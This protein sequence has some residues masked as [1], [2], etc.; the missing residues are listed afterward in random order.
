MSNITGLKYLGKD[1]YPYIILKVP[2]PARDL[3]R[4]DLARLAYQM[5]CSVD[6]LI[7]QLTT[8]NKKGGRVLYEIDGIYICIE[9]G[10]EYK[11]WNGFNKHMLEHA[12]SELIEAIPTE[13]EESI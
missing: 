1:G 6:D 10:K 9:C 13:K 3:N 4:Y 11:T 8:P 7:N 5:E 12:E 2:I